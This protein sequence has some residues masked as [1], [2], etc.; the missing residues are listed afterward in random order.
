MSQTV[1]D[2]LL[3]FFEGRESPSL[4]Y[5]ALFTQLLTPQQL[6]LL[7]LQN[8]TH[9]AL[10]D[11][12]DEIIPWDEFRNLSDLIHFMREMAID[13]YTK[14]KELRDDIIG[15]LL[16]LP[17]NLKFFVAL[18]ASSHS[19]RLSLAETTRMTRNP[20]IGGVVM[21]TAMGKGTGRR[22][23]TPLTILTRC[24]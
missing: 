14:S 20:I 7:L 22:G 3:S 10:Q 16:H 18:M 17:P 6:R 13:I 11:C 21:M 5:L 23:I 12:F 8:L 15:V 2:T 19:R 9:L 24:F 1:P 4:R